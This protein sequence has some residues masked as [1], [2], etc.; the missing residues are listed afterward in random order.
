MSESLYQKTYPPGE[1]LHVLK[2]SALGTQDR[3][4]RRIILIVSG[5]HTHIRCTGRTTCSAIYFSRRMLK[6]R[7]ES[8]RRVCGSDLIRPPIR[9]PPPPVPERVAPARDNFHKNDQSAQIT[10]VLQPKHRLLLKNH[11]L[12][13]RAL[14][15]HQSRHRPARAWLWGIPLS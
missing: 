9:R 7:A 4:A 1:G 6:E 3:R 12:R 13:K 5:S 10:R 15:R 2:A 14:T 8:A 11:D